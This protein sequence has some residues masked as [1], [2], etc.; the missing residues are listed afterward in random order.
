MSVQEDAWWRS[1][2]LLFH[3][4]TRVEVHRALEKHIRDEVAAHGTDWLLTY[5]LEEDAAHRKIPSA[6]Y[7]VLKSY[8]WA[9][10]MGTGINSRWILT[11]KGREALAKRKD[12]LEAAQLR[13]ELQLVRQLRAPRELPVLDHIRRFD[14]EWW[15]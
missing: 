12:E 3:E 5:V 1:F 7:R 6:V 10:R 13:E 2:G 14:A 11:M 9:E 15:D 8:D 4:I